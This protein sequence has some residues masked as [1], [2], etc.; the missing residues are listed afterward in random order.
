MTGRRLGWIN[1]VRILMR[2]FSP[3]SFPSISF[4]CGKP[5]VHFYTEKRLYGT[6]KH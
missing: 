4:F 6:Y 3:N 1:G 2:H 5:Y